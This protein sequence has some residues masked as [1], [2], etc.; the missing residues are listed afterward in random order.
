MILPAPLAHS[1][2]LTTDGSFP[3]HKTQ[4]ILLWNITLH[5]IEFQ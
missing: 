1:C 5:T 2:G 4:A 3:A